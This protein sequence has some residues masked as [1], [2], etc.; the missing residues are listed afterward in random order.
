MLN[1]KIDSKKL[2]LAQIKY[3]DVEHNGLEVTGQDVYAFLYDVNG[4]YVN[5]FNV[6]EEMPVYKRLPYSN[7]TLDGDDYGSKITLAQGEPVDGLSY[8]ISNTSM[9]DLFGNKELDT[10]LFLQ[11]DSLLIDF[12]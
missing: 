1:I 10:E 7:T 4:T 6:F 3:F 8:V 11:V 9:E 5:P 12:L 2:K